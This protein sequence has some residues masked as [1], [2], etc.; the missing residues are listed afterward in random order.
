MEEESRQAEQNRFNLY[1]WIKAYLHKMKGGR[2][3]NLPRTSLPDLLVT[4]VGCLAGLGMVCLL[5]AHYKLPLL[6]PSF[7][8]SAVL[9]YAA[10]HTPMAQP[11]NVI[12]G[13]VLSALT[14][15]AAYKL[16]GGEWWAI[17]VGV[18]LAI[19][20][21]T[22]THT[23]HPPGGATAFMAIY[24]GRDFSFVISPVGVG[25]VLLVIIAVIVNNLSS[26]RKYPQ[27]WF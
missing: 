22:V 11:R 19:L 12:G 10:C 13:H 16:L 24:N 15:V 1:S 23:L 25:V 14:G 9:L 20:V 2:C 7:G 6:L 3:V 4:A 8:A 17:T 26:N 18:T 27:F 5:S 21:M